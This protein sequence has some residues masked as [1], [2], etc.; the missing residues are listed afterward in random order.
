[1]KKFFLSILCIVTIL[2][3][4]AALGKSF[5]NLNTSP[6]VPLVK[7]KTTFFI[8][9]KKKNWSKDVWSIIEFDQKI[10]TPIFYPHNDKMPGYDY[11]KQDIKSELFETQ[12]ESIHWN[13]WTIIMCN[14]F[15]GDLNFHAPFDPEWQNNRDDGF[16][17]Y[18][19]SP[20]DL[21]LSA[22]ATFETDQAY[23][24]VIQYMGLIG[25]IY[26]DP[27]AVPLLSWLY[28][29]EDSVI[30]NEKTGYYESVYPPSDFIWYEDKDI[31]S[32][33]I[34][35]KWILDENGNVLDKKIKAIA[36]TIIQK[37]NSGNALGK[38]ELFWIDYK[39]LAP[40]LAP[41]FVKLD[42]Y[43]KDRII[44]LYEFFNSR[45]FYASEVATEEVHMQKS[46]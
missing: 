20:L 45:E 22:E 33:R 1:M 36:P 19:I 32:Y 5:E 26:N 8:Q 29:D 13:L 16:L 44:S 23:R 35:E 41:Y 21:D 31:V 30:L 24:E 39:Q 18:P 7:S 3:S 40:I 15:K 17:I 25:Q 2:T 34:K 38:R 12:K 46:E 4:T 9:K 43:K 27:Y 14:F 10:N 37:D 6:T 42:R 11:G 28:P